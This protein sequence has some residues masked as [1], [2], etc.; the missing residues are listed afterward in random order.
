MFPMP[1]ISLSPSNLRSD[2]AKQLD[3]LMTASPMYGEGIT[4][5]MKAMND[6]DYDKI[7]PGIVD[8]VRELNEVHGIETSDSGDG[9]HH[10]LGMKCAHPARHVFMHCFTQKQGYRLKERL[11]GL[12]PDAL[13]QVTD[14]DPSKDA[15]V[16]LWPDGEAIYG[17]DG[18]V[19]HREPYT[20]RELLAEVWR[21]L[22][23][24]L[25]FGFWR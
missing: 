17:D 23:L 3:M 24:R 21:L 10:A 18:P 1:N 9:S 13:V 4:G 11:E 7:S 14:P 6:I 22:K 25:S 2:A 16:L 5:R 15:W 20:T 8:L 12:Y 19:R